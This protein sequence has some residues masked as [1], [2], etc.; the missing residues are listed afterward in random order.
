MTGGQPT[1]PGPEPFDRCCLPV[2]TV[3]ITAT[4][5]DGTPVVA[6]NLVQHW[7]GTPLAHLPIDI[8]IDVLNGESE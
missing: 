7:R 5:I 8:C 2:A 6:S 3:G 1:A 4:Y